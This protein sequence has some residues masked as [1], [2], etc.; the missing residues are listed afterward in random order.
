MKNLFAVFGVLVFAVALTGCAHGINIS[1]RERLVDLVA[2][3]AIVQEVEIAAVHSASVDAAT[4]HRIRQADTVANAAIEQYAAATRGCLRS[5]SGEIILDPNASANGATC[6]VNQA[7]TIF[8]VAMAAL[9]ALIGV[10]APFDSA[11][12]Q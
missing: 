9:N 11:P 4:R 8:P 10:L 5:R 7:E 3:Y 12:A 2:R 1:P 6:Q